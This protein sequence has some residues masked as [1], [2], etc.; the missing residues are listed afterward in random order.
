M[1]RVED[2]DT[3]YERALQGGARVSG[4]PNTFPYGE[5]QYTAQDLAGHYWTFSQSVAD[6]DPADWGGQ[7]AG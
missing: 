6:V 7:L 1:V 2:V 4:Q 5:R 3:H